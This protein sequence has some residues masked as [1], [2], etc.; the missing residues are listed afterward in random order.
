MAFNPFEHLTELVFDNL[1]G[2]PPFVDPPRETITL[3]DGQIVPA[4]VPGHASTL[5]LYLMSDGHMQPAT[6]DQGFAQELWLHYAYGADVSAWLTTI[7]NGLA[8]PSEP[9]YHLSD[10]ALKSAIYSMPAL[11][12]TLDAAGFTEQQVLAYAHA[13]AP[14]VML[15]GQV[16]ST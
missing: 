15:V 10:A 6:N 3:L 13:E 8:I 7:Y 11:L 14:D 12:A 4:A 5:S 2:G 1:P 9:G 16:P